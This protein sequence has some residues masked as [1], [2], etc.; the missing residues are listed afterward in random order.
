MWRLSGCIQGP[1]HLGTLKS[2]R[3]N[4]RV[5]A[6]IS[7]FGSSLLQHDTSM[8]EWMNECR[9]CHWLRQLTVAAI[10]LTFVK[11][12]FKDSLDVLETWRTNL[13]L[14]TIQWKNKKQK[15]KYLYNKNCVL[16]WTFSLILSH[17]TASL[18]TVCLG[19][20]LDVLFLVPASTDRLALAQPLRDLLTSMAGS[21]HTVGARDSQVGKL[22]HVVGTLPTPQPFL[23]YFQMAVVVY[24]YRP[25]IWFMLNRHERSDTLLQEIQSTPFD[26]SPGNNIGQ[27]GLLS[28]WNHFTSVL[29]GWVSAQGLCPW[30]AGSSISWWIHRRTSL[31]RMYLNLP[32]W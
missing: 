26:E 13:L 15:N 25:K 31:P 5:A 12:H 9:Q 10:Y 8:N 19:G 24:G 23:C 28:D 11:W 14:R 21:L 30:K 32:P 18:S 4:A 17:S 29:S 2:Y 7:S 22:A 27:F 6:G 3:T 16:Y 1:M 20:R